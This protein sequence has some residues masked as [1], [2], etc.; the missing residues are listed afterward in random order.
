MTASLNELLKLELDGGLLLR[1]HTV[2]ASEAIS[3]KN[4]GLKDFSQSSANMATVLPKHLKSM[5]QLPDRVTNPPVDSGSSSED[6]SDEEV[7]VMP[8]RTTGFKKADDFPA[9]AVAEFQAE[10]N[11]AA[12]AAAAALPK[13]SHPLPPP[14]INSAAVAAPTT[15]HDVSIQQQQ[16]Q[17]RPPVP[18]RPTSTTAP[19]AASHPS[20]HAASPPAIVPRPLS[21]AS[22]SPAAAPPR[23]Q[24]SDR[25]ISLQS[26]AVQSENAQSVASDAASHAVGQRPVT[27]ATSSQACRWTLF[28]F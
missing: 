10:S 4:L 9:G 20:E 12:A 13:P 21:S 6:G 2:R 15:S 24:S 19:P 3:A 18:P 5:P 1:T 25:V 16:H 8:A 7:Q 11:V 28:E 27:V 23:P 17:N 22:A 26:A 14:P